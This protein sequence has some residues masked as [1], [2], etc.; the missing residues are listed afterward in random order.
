MKAL[1]IPPQVLTLE[2]LE[3]IY[4]DQPSSAVQ[5]ALQELQQLGIQIE[6]DDFGSGH[7]SVLSLMAVQP[8]GLKIDKGLVIP[9]LN[10]VERRRLSPFGLRRRGHGAGSARWRGCGW[11]GG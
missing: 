4:L 1:S 10:C 2:L 7:T 8:H 11:C 5:V 3:S 9:T 6:F